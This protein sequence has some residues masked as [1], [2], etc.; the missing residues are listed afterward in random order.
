MKYNQT[1]PADDGISELNYSNT[2]PL[3]RFTKYVSRAKSKNSSKFD[4]FKS[5][6]DF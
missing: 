2:S 1:A 6:P 4:P 5:P 3:L